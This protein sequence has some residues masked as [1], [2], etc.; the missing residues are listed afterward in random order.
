MNR[1]HYAAVL[2]ALAFGGGCGPKEF[3]SLCDDP[4]TAPATCNEACGRVTSTCC[5]TPV[6]W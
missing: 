2:A 4:N 5:A 6:G 1:L 3:G